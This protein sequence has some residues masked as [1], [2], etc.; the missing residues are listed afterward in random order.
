[1]DVNLYQCFLDGINSD[2][3]PF[4]Q[5]DAQTINL[6]K[7]VKL[8]QTK[9]GDLIF[10]QASPCWIRDSRAGEKVALK[11]GI[12]FRKEGKIRHESVTLI[13]SVGGNSNEANFAF[14][15][16]RRALMRCEKAGFGFPSDDYSSWKYVVTI[17]DP[18]MAN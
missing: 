4:N 18:T 10:Q 14:Q 16:A 15:H 11:L 13:D 12:S 9:Y 17:F 1:M 8:K 2:Y 6:I 7:S 3:D 5:K